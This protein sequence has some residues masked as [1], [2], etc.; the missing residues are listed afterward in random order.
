MLGENIMEQPKETSVAR[1]L[2]ALCIPPILWMIYCCCRKSEVIQEH[3]VPLTEQEC[4]KLQD[5]YEKSK[6]RWI[7]HSSYFI[8]WVNGKR[9]R[10]W[11]TTRAMEITAREMVDSAMNLMNYYEAIGTG[12]E[13]EL[14]ILYVEASV[15][16]AYT[17]PDAPIGDLKQKAEKLEKFRNCRIIR[18]FIAK[19]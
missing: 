8:N 4:N 11:K 9:T 19:Y 13:W 15:C 1:V 18:E 2:F 6:R 7:E 14:A 17:M 10:K 3:N 12:R 16:V 5:E